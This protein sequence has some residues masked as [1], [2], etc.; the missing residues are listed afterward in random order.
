MNIVKYHETYDDKKYLYL[1]M[2]LCRGGELFAKVTDTG[3]PMKESEIA[4][5]MTC[6]L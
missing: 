3:K 4:K 1:C 5:E 2:E 6:L